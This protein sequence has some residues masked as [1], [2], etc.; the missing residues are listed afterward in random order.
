MGEE[1]IIKIKAASDRR[2]LLP[3][4]RRRRKKNLWDSRAGFDY[5]PRRR[6]PTGINFY[7]LGLK[8]I[9]S[10]YF[11]L[12]FFPSSRSNDTNVADYAALALDNHG[13][14]GSLL[15]ASDVIME[16]DFRERDDFIIETTLENNLTRLKD[17][18]KKLEDLLSEFE[19]EYEVDGY[20]PVD[21]EV[22]N[23]TTTF[24]LSDF[25]ET[26]NYQWN[27]SGLR[28]G[29]DFFSGEIFDVNFQDFSFR[30]KGVDKNHITTTRNFDA[31]EAAFTPSGNMKIYLFP[32]LICW[33]A[34]S[35]VEFFDSSFQST[36]TPTRGYTMSSANRMVKTH[37]AYR[38][39][40]T[41]F[42][43]RAAGLNNSEAAYQQAYNACAVYASFLGFD[44]SSVLSPSVLFPPPPYNVFTF[45]PNGFTVRI[46][47]AAQSGRAINAN[48]LAAIIE[49][50]KTFYY[51][52]D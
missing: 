29:S 14:S 21:L 2:D 3:P 32:D 47:A 27:G 30:L 45:N 42:C 15:F 26:E 5:L 44:G 18:F 13:Y 16:T 19:T 22:S 4:A 31:L 49:Q 50:N 28:P 48:T 20:F 43:A 7:D 9:G 8:K 24:R 52:W 12:G 37:G 46:E 35:M 41:G 11:D 40:I 34:I 6:V 33:Q 1:I 51:I 38:E 36:F 39:Q 10:A 25:Y 23:G 17:K